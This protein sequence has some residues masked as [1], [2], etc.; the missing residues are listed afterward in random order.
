VAEEEEEEEE[1]ALD[2]PL[3][4][5]EGVAKAGMMVSACMGKPMQQTKK[6]ILFKYRI[7]ICSKPARNLDR[8]APIQLC[9]S[10]L[11][12]ANGIKEVGRN[13]GWNVKSRASISARWEEYSDMPCNM[14]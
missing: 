3:N 9:F 1:E 4:D 7:I 12:P 5:S 14:P 13:Q 2:W 10:P 11:V 8:T 6:P